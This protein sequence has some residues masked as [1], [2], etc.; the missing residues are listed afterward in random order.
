M[1]CRK[2]FTSA[3]G[4]RFCSEHFVIGKKKHE[5][6]V[7]AIVPKTNQYCLKRENLEI[8]WD[9]KKETVNSM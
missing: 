7:P 5:N 6:S 4:H 9:L 1:I 3:S 8:A 2:N